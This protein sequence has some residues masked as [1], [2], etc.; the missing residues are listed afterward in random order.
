MPYPVNVLYIR[1][2]FPKNNQ[3]SREVWSRKQNK[4]NSTI[5]LNVR[6]ILTYCHS[7]EIVILFQYFAY[8]E[9]K[10]VSEEFYL[11]KL[12]FNVPQVLDYLSKNRF[13]IK[14]NFVTLN[15]NLNL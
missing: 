3:H 8:L 6:S 13:G 4:T 11:K 7:I 5:K 2:T 12:N 10:G 1:N 14:S 15:Y 9:N